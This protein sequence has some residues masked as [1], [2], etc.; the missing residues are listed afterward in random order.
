MLTFPDKTLQDDQMDKM[1]HI[2]LVCV[3]M[4]LEGM[5][6]D[7]WLVN[8]TDVIYHHWGTILY[9]KVAKT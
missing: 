8:P 7:N 1:N 4:N 2:Q 3:E 6:A 5:G 9:M